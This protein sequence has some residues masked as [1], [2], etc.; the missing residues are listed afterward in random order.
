MF[1]MI[2]ALSVTAAATPASSNQPANQRSADQTAQTTGASTR[3]ERKY[4]IAREPI[5]GSR[6]SGQTL[7]LTKAEWER[8]GVD[9]E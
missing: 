7:C 1:V 6:M 3:P 5:T 9:V 8:Q 4:C 2:V